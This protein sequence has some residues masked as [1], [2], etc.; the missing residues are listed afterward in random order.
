M[1]L[2]QL[3]LEDMEGILQEWE[4]FARTLPA[5]ASMDKKQLRDHA[6]KILR[7]IARDMDSPQST[8][9]E[10]SRSQGK[11]DTEERGAQD[12]AAQTHGGERLDDGFSAPEMVAEYRAL[13]ASVIRRWRK[14]TGVAS[15]AALAEATRFNEGIDQALAESIKRFSDNLNRSREL[16]MG[17]LGHDLRGP[18]HVILAAAAYLQNLEISERKRADM[19][20]HVLQSAGH[21]RRMIEDLLDVARTKLGGSLPIAPS[22]ADAGEICDRVL[23]EMRALHPDRQFHVETSGDLRGTWDAARLDQL[24]SN[25]VSN[26]LQH[27]DPTKAITIQAQDQGESIRLSVHN[28]GE[29]IP[30]RLLERIFEP[31]VRG[32][33]AHAAGGPA[34]NLGLGLYIASTIARAHGGSI[35]V[36]STKA[37]GTTFSVSLPRT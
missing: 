11:S 10:A 29:P 4:D 21:M 17:A 7:A 37:R 14:Q 8:T 5:A 15:E 26:A 6:E 34:A 32:E 24:L 25:L 35:D 2:A 36:Q 12:S 1:K 22:A 31:L 20:G 18:L 23:A 30:E 19:V 33:K 28:E 27:G 3:I 13:R 16:F 9:E